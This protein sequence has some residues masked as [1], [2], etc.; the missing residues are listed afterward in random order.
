[1]PTVLLGIIPAV[2]AIFSSSW[3]VFVIGC[4][5]ILSGGGDMT[6]VLKLLM[7]RSEKQEILYM[8]HPYEYGLVVFER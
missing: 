3:L 4:I 7:Y 5:M 2:V 8:D 6:I 1:M